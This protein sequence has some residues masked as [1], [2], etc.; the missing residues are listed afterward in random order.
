[1]TKTKATDTNTQST[2]LIV[3]D[4]NDRIKNTAAVLKD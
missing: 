3:I 1:M 4:F 2:V